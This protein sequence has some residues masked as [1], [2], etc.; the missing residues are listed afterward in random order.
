MG[1]E[2]SGFVWGLG[3]LRFGI[4]RRVGLGFEVWGL[5]EGLLVGFSLKLD[6]SR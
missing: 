6:V 3:F 2:G 5:V 1:V 4:L